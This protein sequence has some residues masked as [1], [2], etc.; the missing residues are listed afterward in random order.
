MA[1]EHSPT[2]VWIQGSTGSLVLIFFASRESLVLP[3]TFTSQI[4][5]FTKSLHCSISLHITLTSPSFS[6]LALHA[7]LTLSSHLVQSLPPFHLSASDLYIF[8]VNRSPVASSRCPKNLI[9]FQPTQSVII[10]DF[11]RTKSAPHILIP[12]SNII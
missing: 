9:N 5:S 8:S 10:Y 6:D 7:S 2:S 4:L 3:Y 1:V 12:L 11:S